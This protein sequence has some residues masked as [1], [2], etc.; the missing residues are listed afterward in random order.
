LVLF[1]N[2]AQKLNAGAHYYT[3]IPLCVN[4]KERENKSAAHPLFADEKLAAGFKPMRFVYLTAV[5]LCDKIF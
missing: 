1:F 3:P 2:A 5:F 4:K